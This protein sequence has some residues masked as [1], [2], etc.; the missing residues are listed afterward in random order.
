VSERPRLSTLAVHAGM[1]AAPSSPPAMTTPIFQSSTFEL[2]RCAYEDIERTGGANVLWYTRLGNP[3][4]AAAAAAVAA[5]EGA[6]GALLFS[7]GMAAIT[8]TLEALIPPGGRI[9]AAS[10]LYGD[11]FA[12]LRDLAAERSCQ[13]A[14]VAVDDLDA[15]SRAL[16]G[17]ADVA[18]AESL[19]NPMLRVANLPAIASLAHSAGARLVVD[20]TFAT[21]VNMRPLEH[22]A[23]VVLHSATKYLNG[24]SDLIAGVVAGPRPLLDEVR[25]RAVR[26]GG[27]LDPHAAFLLA[28]GIRT[29]ALRMDRHNA[30]AKVIAERLERH[31]EVDAV[32][33]PLLASHPDRA[34]AEELLGGGSGIVTIRV[35]GGDERALRFLD[36]LH[37]LRQATS[38][39]GLE[40]L[41]SAP[42]NTSHVALSAS[43][44]ERLGILPGTIRLSIGL[45]DP[46]D[47]IA[48]LEDALESSARARSAETEVPRA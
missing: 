7:S 30:T 23:D 8:A 17:G 12:V 33:Y 14:Y 20:S 40:S 48:D 15:W 25:E 37:L 10:A 36:E 4:V 38:L 28:R 1:D 39:G 18:Y 31:P 2:S 22:D 21:P 5:L 44:R 26:L 41:A 42:F 6:D 3:T 35:R 11:T 32:H 16:A 9:V 34:L 19:S 13:V 27:C 24:H 45:E 46:T 29:L 47:L 43:E